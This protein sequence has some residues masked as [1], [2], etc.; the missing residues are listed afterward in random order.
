M[1]K[2]RFLPVMRSDGTDRVRSGGVG[3]VLGHSV[4]AHSIS[5]FGLGMKVGNVE[6]T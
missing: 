6:D 5:A 2:L 1:C 3:T 4:V